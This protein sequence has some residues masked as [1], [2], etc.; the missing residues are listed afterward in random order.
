MLDLL[1]AARLH[2]FTRQQDAALVMTCFVMQAYYAVAQRLKH[3][4][5]MKVAMGDTSTDRLKMFPRP[6]TDMLRI[7]Q[8]RLFS[9]QI[10]IHT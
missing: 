9:D 10:M 1:Q 8:Q 5:I 3:R 6:Q 7:A 2:C 4:L